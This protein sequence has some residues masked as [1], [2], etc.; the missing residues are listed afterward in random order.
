ME[1]ILEVRLWGDADDDEIEMIIMDNILF[2][3][4]HVQQGQNP[5]NLDDYTDEEIVMNFQFERADLPVLFEVSRIPEDVITETGNK[6]NGFTALCILLKRLVYP[7]RL[8][9]LVPMFNLSAQSLSQIIRTTED[10][11][12]EKTNDSINNLNRLQ[13][14]NQEKL[15]YYAEA[16]TV[17]CGAVSNCWGFIDGTTRQICR[18]TI[19]QEEYYSGHKRYHC[20]KYQSALCPD[21]KITSLKGGFPVRRHDAGI[22]RESLLYQELQQKAVFGS[23]VKYVLYGDQAY[24]LMDL[25]LT[26]FPEGPNILPHQQQFNNSM[27]TLRVSVEGDFK[28]L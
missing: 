23:H 6:V 24:G 11:I 7:N 27:K 16:V 8:S 22:F 9:E 18:P 17:K 26:S 5:F 10:L 21:G 4:D 12:Y 25:L 28:K 2:D 15:D 20:I 1:E 3:R 19:N 13:W 14:L